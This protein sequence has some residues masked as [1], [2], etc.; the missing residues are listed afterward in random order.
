MV[1]VELIGGLGNQMFQYAVGRCIAEKLQTSLQLNVSGFEKYPLRCYE[2]NNFNIQVQLASK[3]DLLLFSLTTKQKLVRSVKNWFGKHD[4]NRYICVQ[5]R[6]FTFDPAV[7]QQQGNLYLTGYWQS[8]KYFKDIA[9]IL[10]KEFSSR[11]P[12]SPRSTVLQEKMQRPG[13]VAIHIRRGDYVTNPQTNQMHGVM[14]LDYYRKAM[15]FIAS[16]Q[17]DVTYYIFSDDVPWVRQN[18]T[19]SDRICIV[20][21]DD[22]SQSYEDMLLMSTCNHYIIA[23]SSFSWWSAWLNSN[24]NKIVIA[25]NKWFNKAEM[26]TTDLIPDNWIRL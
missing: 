16:R 13:S 12:L 3:E 25:P 14:S 6:S 20:E 10:R 2:L 4:D 9:S 19:V 11:N 1:I 26:D 18:F 8:E 24:P 17:E 21:P 22:S 5:E 15:D 7:L 23:N